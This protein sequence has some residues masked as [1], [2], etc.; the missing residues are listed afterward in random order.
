MYIVVLHDGTWHSAWDTAEE[1]GH[2]RDALNGLG[3]WGVI[4]IHDMTV[5]VE[6]GHYYDISKQREAK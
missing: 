1:A 4:V 3:F 5:M 6:N 2:Q